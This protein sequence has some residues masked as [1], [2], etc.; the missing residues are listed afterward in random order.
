[1][2]GK[3]IS[4][5]EVLDQNGLDKMGPDDECIPAKNFIEADNL[6]LDDITDSLEKGTMVVL[7]ACFYH[8]EHIQHLIDNLPYKHFEFTLKAPLEVCIERDANRAKTHGKDAAGAVHWLVSKFDH[9]KIV[10]TENKTPEETLEEVI[11]FIN[12]C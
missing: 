5:D 12:R 6:I 1:M 2:G 7:D 9:G 3:Y 8:K 4:I 11:S 10:D